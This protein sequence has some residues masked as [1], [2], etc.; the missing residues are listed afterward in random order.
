MGS[1]T[2]FR[3]KHKKSGS[4]VFAMA[5][6]WDASGAVG[7]AGG[8]SRVEPFASG[9][10]AMAW[11]GEQF[12]VPADAW[13]AVRSGYLAGKGDPLPPKPSRRR[14]PRAK[15]AVGPVA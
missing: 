13:R 2:D 1:R 9:Q 3:I 14:S 10:A 6:W 15:K 7:Q 8:L 12:E 4:L 5:R 11:V